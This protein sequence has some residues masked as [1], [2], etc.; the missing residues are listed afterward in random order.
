[1]NKRDDSTEEKKKI[2]KERRI[3]FFEGF[4]FEEKSSLKIYRAYWSLIK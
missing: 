2:R 1:M 4:V 3:K